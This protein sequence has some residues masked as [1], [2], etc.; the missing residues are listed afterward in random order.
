MG[1]SKRIALYGLFIALAFVFSYLEGLLAIQL[2]PGMKLG[3][4]NLVV[5]VALYYLD[6]KAAFVINMVRI[7]CVAFTFGNLYSLCYSAAGGMLSYIV[8]VLLKKMKHF[9]VVMVSITGSI[10]HNV[11]Q[12]VVAIFMVETT[13]VAWYLSVLIF[14]GIIA[15]AMIGL[16]GGMILKRLP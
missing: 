15:G 1:K 7:L 4:T 10:F 16:L 8:M 11:G 13:A 3:L 6:V 5:L 14:S 2:M 12:V 9:S